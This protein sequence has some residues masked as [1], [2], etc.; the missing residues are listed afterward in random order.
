[1]SEVEASPSEDVGRGERN[2]QLIGEAATLPVTASGDA[3]KMTL[4]SLLQD[5]ARTQYFGRYVVLGMLGSGAMG[6]VLEA[7]DRSLDRRVAVK[8]L[9]TRLD[10]KARR[11]MLREAQAMAKLSHPNV[12]Q[13]YEVDTVDGQTFIAME[14]VH[15]QTLREWMNRDPRPDWRACVEVFIQVG[16]GLAAA[17]DAGLV[18]RDF[19]PDN[20]VLDDK[21]RARVLDFGLARKT[22]AEPTERELREQE[23]DEPTATGTPAGSDL[24]ALDLALTRTGARVGT[25]AYMPTEQMMGL[26]ADARSDQFSFCVSLWEALYGERPFDGG[27]MVALLMAMKSETTRPA[28]KGSMVPE[29]L[30]VVVQRGLAADPGAR[31]PSMAPLLEQLRA[32]V[33]PRARR[34]L[35][36]GV[37]IGLAGLGMVLAMPRIL[38]MRERCTG[39][40]A[41]LDGSW[42][43]TRKGQVKDAI[44]GTALSYAPATW[45]RVE[46]RLDEYAH[47]WAEVHTEVCEATSVRGDQTPEVMS[48]RMS[49]LHARK[50]AL[51]AAVDVLARANPKVVEKAV[52]SVSTLPA[53]ERCN[54]VRGLEQQRQRVPPPDDPTVAEQ[55]EALRDQLI[56]IEA[57]KAAAQYD[58]ALMQ[59]EQVVA[60]AEALDYRPLRAEAE[61]WQGALLVEHG[62]YAEAEQ[63]LRQALTRAF[64][65]GHDTVVLHATQ[66]LT[67]L[68]G[69][70]LS[71]PVEGQIWGQAAVSLAKHT[72]QDTELALSLTSLGAVFFRQ[73]EFDQ[74]TLCFEQAL[75]LREA[76]LGPD[77]PT[78]AASLNDLGAVF[79]QRGK[80]EQ[81]I[82][83]HQR[84]LQ[85]KERALGPDHPSV[86]TS[87]GNLAY[88]LHDQG[89]FE[90]AKTYLLRA[91]DIQT[92]ALGLDH[93]AVATTLNGLG[94]VLGRLGEYEAA[95]ASFERALRMKESA[96]G[97]D[98]LEVA[99]SLSNLA[100]VLRELGDYEQAKAHHLRALRIREV[101]MGPDHPEVA[102]TLVGLANV[103]LDQRD[104]DAAR[105]Y[106]ERVVSIREQ[107]EAPPA[108]LAE[109]RFLLAKAL[110]SDPTQ[111]AR[112]R[113]LA[114]QARDGYAEH[115]KGYEQDVVKAEEWLATTRPARSTS[116]P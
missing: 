77:H 58:P 53:V 100:N 67:S 85:I 64:E 104:V 29:E 50:M 52:Q 116:T 31:W 101:A 81:A 113:A 90:Q 96:L 69:Q 11:R 28:P 68:V 17:H 55:V 33:A 48:L 89:D 66:Q 34:G 110:W 92:S 23:A 25:P 91:L 56:T 27:S 38:E 51:G 18:H 109:A 1:M 97:P 60:Q 114:E 47:A 73:A 16:Q 105:G 37:T 61:Q 54:D 49:C 35:V 76:A 98:H 99:Q 44:L 78:V 9:H 24:P 8:V 57:L 36:A 41:Q 2:V 32:L 86:A 22:E 84:A 14:L 94:G 20:A 107:I 63:V 112:A 79:R 70:V 5:P 71:R 45:E 7:F 21:G 65:H 6:T 39:A 87:L 12:V 4:G 43:D 82:A 3:R 83:H 95:K 106:A 59:A 40:R 88:V 102:Y 74:A 19:K 93:P 108:R 62:R 42:D 26:E 103:A 15:G 13:V 72:G 115:G 80:Y 46:S 30:R 111:R 75:Q 10:E